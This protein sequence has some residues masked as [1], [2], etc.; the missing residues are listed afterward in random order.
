MLSPILF[1]VY[2]DSLL[3]ALCELGYGCYWHSMIADTSCYADGL[4]ILVP[5]ADGLRKMLGVREEFAG[6]HHV[7]F[8]PAKT[9]PIHLV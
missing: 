9:H 7:R 1:N 5:S 3:C 8:N 4:T 6:S 2:V